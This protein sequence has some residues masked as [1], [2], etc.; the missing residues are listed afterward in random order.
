MTRQEVIKRLN[1]GDTL[2]ME[3]EGLESSFVV[4]IRRE[5]ICNFNRRRLWEH[6]DIGPI[7][8]RFWGNG[9]VQWLHI[10]EKQLDGFLRRNFQ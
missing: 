1:K 4:W 7:H 3:F 6:E 9:G 10:T 5:E 2:E 8:M